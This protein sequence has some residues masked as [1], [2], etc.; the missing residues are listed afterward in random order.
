MIDG[1]V[2]QKK[3]LVVGIMAA[4]Q[5]HGIGYKS[6]IPWRLKSDMAFFR[7]TTMNS[8]VIYGSNT[9]K[10]LPVLKG[11]TEILLTRKPVE[12]NERTSKIAAVCDS[13]ESALRMAA[14]LAPREGRQAVYVIGGAQVY[15]AFIPYYDNFLLTRIKAVVQADTHFNTNFLTPVAGDS[16]K[17]TVVHEVEASEKDEFAFTIFEYSRVLNGQLAGS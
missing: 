6:Q 8:V 16:W 14:I 7:E 4:D 3:L 9:L 15:E 1:I 12:Q 5:N 13:V 11:R 17:S 10:T 2:L